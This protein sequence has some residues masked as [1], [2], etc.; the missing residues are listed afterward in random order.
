MSDLDQAAIWNINRAGWNAAAPR[1][2]GAAALPKYGPFAQTEDVLD[3]LG[4]VRDQAVLEIG[5]GSGHSLL[6][7]AQHRARDLWGVDLST[8]QIEFA[9]ALLQEHGYSAH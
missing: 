3:L 1:F 5:C 9:Q 7:L 6:F 4:D 8:Q 2:Y